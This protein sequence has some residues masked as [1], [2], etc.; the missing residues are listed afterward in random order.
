MSISRSLASWGALRFAPI[1]VLSGSAVLGQA[2]SRPARPADGPPP[3]RRQHPA[4]RP[5]GDQGPDPVGLLEGRGPV[6]GNG[7]ARAA[8]HPGWVEIL[9][10]AALVS[11]A[12]DPGAEGGDRRPD[13]GGS[14][15]PRPARVLRPRLRAG[16]GGLD[17]G[18]RHAPDARRR[19]PRTRRRQPG[20]SRRCRGRPDLEGGPAGG[21]QRRP[22]RAPEPDS[23]P[24]GPDGR[25]EDDPPG[26]RGS[27]LLV[28]AG[29]AGDLS[30]RADGRLDGRPDLGALNGH[31]QGHRLAESFDGVRRGPADGDRRAGPGLDRLD[32]GGRPVRR[33]SLEGL[34]HGGRPDGLIPELHRPPRPR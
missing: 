12:P 32:R 18:R 19:G 27:D 5:L 22:E 9:G 11:V 7:L 10:R 8:D 15:L 2:P 24:M 31:R 25:P 26:H 28:R 17:R 3:I 1:A 23:L 30:I 34:R 21:A 33:G 13:Q 6:R 20:P 29:R 14:P 4:G 16:G